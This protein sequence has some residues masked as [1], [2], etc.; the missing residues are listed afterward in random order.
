MKA[1]FAVMNTTWAVEKIRPK[2]IQA[3]TGFEPITSVILMW[4]SLSYSCLYPQFK[5][6]TF[7]Y[8]QSFNIVSVGRHKYVMNLSHFSLSGY[9][10]IIKNEPRIKAVF[11]WDQSKLQSANYTSHLYWLITGSFGNYIHFA[12]TFVT[13]LTNLSKFFK[14]AIIW[15]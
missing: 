5:Y 3:C 2:K 13:L 9:V 11:T 10:K 12:L 4:R 15:K 8:S 7:I 14:L 6:M 1:I